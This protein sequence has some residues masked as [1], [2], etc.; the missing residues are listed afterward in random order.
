MTIKIISWLNENAEKMLIFP[1]YFCARLVTASEVVQRV[2][3]KTSWLWSTWIAIA[4]FVWFAW[5]ACSWNVK[6]RSHLRFGAFRKKMSP[7]VQFVLLLLDY[8]LWI[9]FGV[10]TSYFCIINIGLLANIEALIYG[11]TIPRWVVPLCIPVSFCLLF[12]RILQC[13]V[14]DIKALKRNEVVKLVIHSDAG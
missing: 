9:I 14:E 6:T 7:R 3:F 11:S 1:L 12:F 8:T 2:V 10:I 5:I 13:L 4:L